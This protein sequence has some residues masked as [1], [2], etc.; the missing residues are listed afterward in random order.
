[1]LSLNVVVS[2]LLSTN[3]NV[4]PFLNVYVYRYIG[5]NILNII[6]IPRN[7]LKSLCKTLFLPRTTALL[8]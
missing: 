7:P 3:P 6:L 5:G 1:M 4:S 8:R 2:V